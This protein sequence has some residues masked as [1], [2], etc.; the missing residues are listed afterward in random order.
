MLLGTR[1]RRL[2]SL[3]ELLA[4]DKVGL[5]GLVTHRFGLD[6]IQDAYDVFGDAAQTGAIKVALFGDEPVL[7][8]G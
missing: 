3:L 2:P 8:Q 5:P 6:E 7:R 1:H 4:A